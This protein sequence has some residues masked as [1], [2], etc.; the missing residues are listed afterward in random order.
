MFALALFLVCLLL[1]L[2]I[3]IPIFV[4][5]GLSSIT[6]WLFEFG[7]LEP[8]VFMQRMFAGLGSFTLMAIPF[9]M[10]CGELMNIAGLSKRLAMFAQDIIGWVRGGLG[11]T[12]ILTSM[13]IAA[14]LGSASACAAL[15]GMVMI[16]EMLARGYRHDFS[17]ALVASAGAIGPIIP[18]SIP[19]I[20]Y[21]VI[22]Q[23]SVIKLFIGGYIPGIMMG[24]AFML[25]TYIHAR[26]YNYPAEKFPTVKSIANSFIS[27][28]PTLLLPIIIMG[29][30][31]SGLFTP[32]EAGVA[33]VVYAM[34]VGL[35]I[36]R[37]E[38][39]LSDLPKVFIRAA[40]NT[41]M[42]LMVISTATLLSWVLTLEQIPQTVSQ[43]MLSITDS[44]YVFLI[45]INLFLV[46]MGMFLDSVSG[47]TILAPVLLPAALALGVDPL[48]FG[49]MMV[50]NFSV[51][52]ITPPVGLNLYVTSS[53]AK[54]DI[55]T[56][57]KSAIPFCFLIFAVLMMMVFFP[58]IVTYLP[59]LMK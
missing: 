2:F 10:L 51:G 48:F 42:V 53:I 16:P 13:F 35:V 31:M 7:A 1:L 56:L 32:T 8:A 59:E 50:V 3:R 19:L 44:K 34:L 22:A 27:A 57:S 46:V 23:V 49:V 24:V 43:I 12:V 40:C 15:I 14:I 25:Y 30:I 6:L 20:V 36:Y 47:I 52:A 55:V 45:I 41:A 5:L 38:L 29:G 37:K 9:F 33:G 18:P 26:K 21:G 11:F 17:S 28:L 54:I 39:K 58:E 4:A